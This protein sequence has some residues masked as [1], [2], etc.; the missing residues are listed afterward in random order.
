MTYTY[1]YRINEV[2]YI[3][4]TSD[5]QKREMTH[6]SV[7]NNKND[8]NYNLKIY[9]KCRELNITFIKLDI[10]KRTKMTNPKK[11]E[12]YYINKYDS[13]NSGSNERN[14]YTTPKE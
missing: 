10:I 8:K 1:I 14:A 12:Q 7:Y 4:S 9:I 11:L 5:I 13:I 6:N 3:G 2:N